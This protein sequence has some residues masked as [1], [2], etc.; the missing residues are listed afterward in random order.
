MESREKTAVEHEEAEPIG[1]NRVGRETPRASDSRGRSRCSSTARRSKLVPRPRAPARGA[2]SPGRRDALRGR[3]DRV[4]LERRGAGVGGE[5][6][7]AV[8]L[9][10]PA[11]PPARAAR[12]RAGRL[13]AARRGGGARRRALRA[14]CSPTAAERSPTANDRLADSLFTRA[15]DLWRGDVLA[16]LGGELFARAEALRLRRAPAPVRRGTVRGRAAARPARGARSPISSGSSPSIRSGSA[17][18]R[19]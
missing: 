10:A 14:S 5:R 8:R 17:C 19:S 12:H 2:D 7:S 1:V 11:R 16:G 15:L 18:A 3:A 9:A 4:G 6:P 13:P